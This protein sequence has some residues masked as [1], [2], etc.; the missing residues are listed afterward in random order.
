MPALHLLH[1]KLAHDDPDEPE[2][3][4]WSSGGRI[5]SFCVVDYSSMDADEDD[6]ECQDVMREGETEKEHL[7][8]PNCISEYQGYSGWRIAANEMRVRLVAGDHL[9]GTHS[10][11]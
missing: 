2:S 9:T 4:A 8:G 1:T 6:A 5:G 10:Y 7:A 11:M 3:D